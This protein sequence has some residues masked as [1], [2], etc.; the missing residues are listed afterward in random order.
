[1]ATSFLSK[2]YGLLPCFC[3]HDP[4]G[5]MKRCQASTLSKSSNAFWHRHSKSKDKLVSE[6]KQQKNNSTA[7]ETRQTS[8]TRSNH[9]KTFRKSLVQR[10]KRNKKNR[11]P[12]ITARS[13]IHKRTHTNVIKHRN[14]TDHPSNTMQPSLDQ[15]L[16]TQSDSKHS[17]YN[18]DRFVSQDNSYD[19]SEN[20]E[21]NILEPP[22]SS[23][24]SE[25]QN[26]NATNNISRT[27]QGTSQTIM[28]DLD[29]SRKRKL[30]TGKAI[31][32]L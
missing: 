22:I 19:N 9:F 29:S 25:Q 1:M 8:S 21:N 20:D 5:M 31:D 27:I 3:D 17:S 7:S 32:K 16:S 12:T 11:M 26:I 13:V 4:L 24:K 23:F 30:T 2:K 10:F 15:P 6:K 14:S 28:N 18:S